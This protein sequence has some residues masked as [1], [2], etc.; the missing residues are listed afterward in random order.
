MNKY[1]EWITNNKN[2]KDGIKLYCYIMLE[3]KGEKFCY[4]YGTFV[5]IWFANKDASPYSY[6]AFYPR[7]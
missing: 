3:V 5:N 1:V 4:Q 7:I 2:N 6:L